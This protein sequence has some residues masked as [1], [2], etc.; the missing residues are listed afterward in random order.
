MVVNHM[1]KKKLEQKIVRRQ[2]LSLSSVEDNNDIVVE[3]ENQNKAINEDTASNKLEVVDDN[4]GDESQKTKETSFR[5]K[6]TRKLGLGVALPSTALLAACDPEDVIDAITP[7]LDPTTPPPTPPA[8]TPPPAA[9]PAPPTTLSAPSNNAEASRF[10]Q[11]AQFSASFSEMR[12]LRA[13]GYDAWLNQQLD[14]PIEQTAVARL[15][16]IGYEDDPANSVQNVEL[17]FHNVMWREL[18]SANDAVRKRLAFAL[19]QFF[20]VGSGLRMQYLSIGYAYYW[21]ILNKG[22]TGNFRDLLEDVTLSPAMGRYLNMHGN[23]KGDPASGRLPDENFAREILQLFSIGLIELNLDGTPRLDANGNEILTYSND[24]IVN[25]A[26]VFTGWAWDGVNRTRFSDRTPDFARTPMTHDHTVQ[27]RSQGVRFRQDEHS[28]LEANFLGTTVP[29]NTD[30]PTS[31]T[32]ALD[33]IFEHPN[34]GPF[35]GRQMIQRLVTSNPSA[36]YVRRV[37]RVF[38]NNG[39]GVRGD[40]RAVFIAILTDREA[41]RAPDL[42][43]NVSGRLRE[44]LLRYIQWGRTFGFNSASD[45]WAIGLLINP[46]FNFRQRALGSPSVFNFF[47]PGFTPAGT[48]IADNDLVAPE[49]QLSNEVTNVTYLNFMRLAIENRFGTDIRINYEDEIA[50]ADDARRLVNRVNLLLTGDQL[51]NSTRNKIVTAVE[52]IAIPAT[53]PENALANRVRIAIFLTM[54][55]SDYLIKK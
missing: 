50:I 36:G 12:D 43:N 9:S 34:V 41:V 39:S 18:F 14:R 8:P 17:P 29:A 48:A 11:N 53:S 27:F 5:N 37:A 38:N 47:R 40:L 55:S 54:A 44:P 4:Q 25:L 16:E 21:D 32:I 23:R 35:F 24:E 30:A 49:F 7:I 1:I 22:V 33:A 46:R 45:E 3:Q 28:Q 52:S 2:F 31:L 51:S 13:M 26:R 6:F 20:V 19:S 42:S 15:Q 10:L